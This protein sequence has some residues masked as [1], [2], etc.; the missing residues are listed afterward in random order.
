MLV[1]RAFEITP[2]LDASHGHFDIDIVNLQR[3][4]KVRCETL[5]EYDQWMQTFV[6]LKK[7]AADFLDENKNRFDSFAPVREKQ[8]GSW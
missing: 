4:I 1:D 3:K 8:L 2:H 6:E 5:N 7:T